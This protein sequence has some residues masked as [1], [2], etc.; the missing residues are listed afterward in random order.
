M[1]LFRWLT[2]CSCCGPG[3]S[4]TKQ[5]IPVPIISRKFPFKK[6][7]F[8]YSCPLF[9]KKL[10]IFHHLD[11]LLYQEKSTP[12]S[13]R[14]V[15]STKPK[16]TEKLKREMGYTG[17]KSEKNDKR[18]INYHKNRTIFSQYSTQVVYSTPTTWIH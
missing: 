18:A 2:R 10:C 4:N 6:P 5:S 3:Q 17:V 7:Q 15:N 14:T 12:C 11:K 9:K 1:D 13:Q 16:R 8:I